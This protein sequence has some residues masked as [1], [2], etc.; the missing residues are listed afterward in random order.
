MRRPSPMR[1]YWIWQQRNTSFTAEYPRMIPGCR[2]CGRIAGRII[3][4]IFSLKLPS[5]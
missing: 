2:N 3:A 4:P 1:F 5:F